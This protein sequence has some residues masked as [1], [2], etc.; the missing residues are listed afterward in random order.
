MVVAAVRGARVVGASAGDCGA[1]IVT[2]RIDDLTERQVRKPL[3][4]T[5]SAVPVPFE[6][7]LGTGTLVLASDG[8]F[9]YARRNQI[10]SLARDADIRRSA[11]QLARLPRLRSGELQ[12]DVAIVLCRGEATTEQR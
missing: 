2:E 4:G 12:D 5:G 3:I 1:W 8:L 6:A 10:A 11:E 7:G 9:K